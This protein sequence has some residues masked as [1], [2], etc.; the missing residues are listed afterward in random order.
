[1]SAVG[2]SKDSI[3][4]AAIESFNFTAK[5][6]DYFQSENIV[7]ES[8]YHRDFYLMNGEVRD[9]NYP[10]NENERNFSPCFDYSGENYLPSANN[11]GF[12]CVSNIPQHNYNET[13]NVWCSIGSM[14]NYTSNGK[15]LSRCKFEKLVE[16][17]LGVVPVSPVY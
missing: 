11:P 17:P 2:S 14:E 15:K 12:F 3:N 13:S 5:T 1:M 7:Y 6:F 8:F 16:V 4:Y 9:S 10:V